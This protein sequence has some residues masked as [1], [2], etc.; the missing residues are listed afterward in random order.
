M[1]PSLH[2]SAN[3]GQSFLA[4]KTL[5][6][7]SGSPG[8]KCEPLWPV[9]F[10][11]KRTSPQTFHKLLKRATTKRATNEV[12]WRLLGFLEGSPGSGHLHFLALEELL[13]GLQRDWAQHCKGRGDSSCAHMAR[14]VPGVDL[15]AQGGCGRQR[16]EVLGETSRLRVGRVMEK[17]SREGER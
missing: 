7:C 4:N 14:W 10:P 6:K 17:P 2:F 5:G 15:W 16:C 11:V 8:N 13:R 3:S 1:L 12:T 9:E